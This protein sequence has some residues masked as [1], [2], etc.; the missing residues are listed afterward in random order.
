[1]SDFMRGFAG[2]PAGKLSATPVPNLFFSE[3]LPLIDDLAELKVTLHL[4]WLIGKKQGALRY[5]RLEELLADSR[6]LEG[7]ADSQP[8]AE[9]ILRDALERAIARGTLLHTTVHRGDVTEEWYMVNSANGREVMEKLRGGELDL[10]ADV[11][12]DVQLQ[13]ERPAIFVLYEQNIG[14]LTPMMTE[15][16]RD[17]ERHF[18]ADWIA[19]AFRE[20]VTNNKRNWKYVRAILERW[21]VQGKG[22][23]RDRRDLEDSEYLRQRY[24]SETRGH[25]VE[26]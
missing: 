20:A 8:A 4:F 16:L 9:A 13:V 19:D 1:M 3:L 23:D 7:L 17:A 12:E 6:L 11:A 24:G 25:L 15:E 21:R 5:A 22:T 2:F 14:L 10:L 18:P 26:G